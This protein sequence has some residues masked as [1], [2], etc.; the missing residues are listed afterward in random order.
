MSV[1]LRP[2]PAQVMLQAV[3]IALDG[4]PNLTVVSGTVRVYTLATGVEVDVLAT[5]PLARVGSSSTWRLAW[6]PASLAVGQYVAEYRLVDS[7]GRVSLTIED[8]DVHDLAL[9]ADLAVVRAVETGRW[10][11]VNNQ[12]RFYDTTNTLI[13]T[14]DLL[15]LAG[16][17]TMDAVYQRVPV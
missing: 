16:L 14:F 11:I 4:T 12:M 1:L 5:T 17:P 2:N 10:Q 15:D 13:L 3:A 6:T 9:Q 7:A 8:V